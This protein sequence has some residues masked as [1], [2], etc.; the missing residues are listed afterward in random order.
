MQLS[1]YKL[2]INESHSHEYYVSSALNQAHISDIPIAQTL[3][4]LIKTPTAT[5]YL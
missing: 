3:T 2:L 1:K 4:S 5:K